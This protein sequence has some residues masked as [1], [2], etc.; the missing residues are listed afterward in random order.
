MRLKQKPSTLVAAALVVIG[1]ACVVLVNQ[2]ATPYTIEN[3]G[4]VVLVGAALGGIY[5]ITA[6]GLVVTYATTG[7]FNFAHAAIGAFLAFVYW[8]L[9]VGWGWPTLLSL[10]IVLLVVAPLL[11]VLLDKVLMRRL[12][13]AP[14]VVQ[15]VVTVGLM[16]AF[17][18]LTNT[19]WKPTTPRASPFL[20]DG[21]FEV[22]GIT[23]TWHRVITVA[24]AAA[25][26]IALRTFLYRTRLGVSMRAVV[27]NRNLAALT[28]ARPSVASGA[29]WS[30]GA[31]TA[32]LAGILIAP[33]TGMEVERLTLIIVVAFAAAAI[34][35][36]RSLPLAF[37]GGM[38]IGLAKAYTAVF[39][40]FGTDWN[41]APE[42]VPA[43]ILFIAV[44]FLPD[45]RLETG[46]VRA[47]K[48][49]ERLTRP[50]EAL[51]ASVGIVGIVVVW[52]NGWIPFPGQAFGERTEIWLGRGAGFLV[53]GLIMLSLVP[54]IGWA[55][56]VS[57]A[58]YAI[59]GIGALLFSH[60]GGQDG[61]PFAV[62]LVMLV[63]APLGA[64]IALPALRVK[65][66]YLALATMAFAEFADKV[67]VRHPSLLD[68]TAVGSLYEPM[69][70]FGF[71]LSSDAADREAFVIFLAIV[72]AVLFFLLSLLRRSRWAR[73]WIAMSDS[74]AASA[75]IGVNLTTSKI[76]VFAL[77]GAIAGFAG[78]MLGLASGSFRVD[79]F[80]L[81]AGLP[82]VLLLAAQGV[83]YP[84]AAFTAAIALAGFPAVY[85]LL[86]EPSWLSSIELIG[87]GI[88]AIAMAYRPEGTV[89]YAGR[90]LA[91]HLPWRKDAKEDKALRV[92]KLR[93]EDITRDEIN[94]LGLTRP[95][96][97][98]TVARLDRAL[99][100]T[101][102]LLAGEWRSGSDP[103]E[104]RR[105]KP[106]E[107]AR[108]AAP[109]S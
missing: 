75:T 74:P 82:L 90:N 87:P 10:A 71:R 36:L 80:P 101:D 31:M 45:A 27:D 6:C 4:T 32:G 3:I 48:R 12:R 77:S 38:I 58:N 62:V 7:V 105:P 102:Q 15:L 94:D 93:S 25:I 40:S 54:L 24:L 79:S 35:Q 34:A 33:E 21:G 96:T 66:L 68:P 9:R 64:V 14:L 91:A 73:R 28:G 23:A 107:E 11:G 70:I 2:S 30:L 92:A 22:A 20:I 109:V 65:G 17:M 61:D 88:A 57:F 41:Y 52:A 56:Q 60:F 26:A 42:A 1:V 108:G 50:G 76:A 49:T 84:I 43:V 51:L 86:G 104:G 63:C 85:E 53:V 59:A 97:P 106:E 100:V 18:G 37:V 39:M 81:F 13:Q 29:A 47:T 67:I 98:D 55:G 5:A 46:S 16:L 83:R 44:L 78:C 72:F 19:I 95:F 89:F 69:Q 103:A 99:G 8:Q